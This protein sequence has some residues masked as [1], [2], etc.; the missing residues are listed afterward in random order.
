MF[1]R[2]GEALGSVRAEPRVDPEPPETVADEPVT[3][4]E[5]APEPVLV[6]KPKPYDSKAEWVAYVVA[7]TVDSESP[8][9]EADADDLTKA[10]LIELYGGEA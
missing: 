4:S 10:E 6:E 2:N 8:V 9:S 7:T 5:P 1:V 3:D